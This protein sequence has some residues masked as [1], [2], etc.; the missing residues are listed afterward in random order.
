MSDPD[1]TLTELT[2]PAPPATGSRAGWQRIDWGEAARLLAGGAGIVAAAAALGC[3]PQRLERN[4]RR[5]AKF[6]HRIDRMHAQMQ[7]TARLRFAA[8]GDAAARQMQEQSKLDGRLLQWMGDRLNLARAGTFT[9]AE[10]LAGAVQALPRKPVKSA[11][12]PGANGI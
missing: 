5:S 12:K 3:E 4:L 7:L 10:E 9:T 2:L 11:R 1:N 6:R 8:L